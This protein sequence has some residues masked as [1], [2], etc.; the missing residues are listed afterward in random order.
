METV[1]DDR[2]AGSAP[3][4]PPPARASFGLREAGIVF[5]VAL[6]LRLV[7]LWCVRDMPFVEVPIVDARAYDEWGQRIA[8]GDWWGSEVFY[9][10]PLYPYLL[11]SFYAVFGHQ[12]MG[13]HVLQMTMGAA[14]CVLL[15]LGAQALFRD[16][17]VALATGLAIAAYPPAIFFDGLI[18]KQG[19]G[20][21]LLSALLWVWLRQ[22]VLARHGE[23]V[24]AGAL[25]GLLCLTR[26]NALA[27]VPAMAPW[28]VWRFWPAG[29][30][31]VALLLAL[32]A[33]GLAALL[34]PVGLRNLA[35]GDTFALTTSQMGPNFYIGNHAGASGLYEPLLPGRQ[36]PV[37]EATDA[38]LL[39]ER[40]LGRELTRGEVSDHW[41]G[42]GLA[43]VRDEPVAWLGLMLRKTV[44]T[45][46]AFEIPDVEDVYV[47]AD[48][49]PIIRY[50]LPAYHFGWIAALAAAGL[51]FA[52]PRRRDVV[53]LGWL[54]LTYTGSVA[55]F[56]TFARFRY[57]LVPMLAPL[58]G[59]ALVEVARS[60]R[61]RDFGRLLA[62]ATVFVFVFAL[63]GIDLVDR[64]GMKV[65]SLT[66]LG[67]IMLEADRLE[68][69]EVWLQRAEAARPE[70]PDLQLHLAVLREA[71]GRPEEALPHLAE[72]R[73]LAPDDHRSWVLLARI[74][75]AQGKHAEAARARQ[76]AR[77]LD[78]APPASRPVSPP[79]HRDAVQSGR[80]PRGVA[81]AGG[82]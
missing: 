8:A 34:V 12:L 33:L 29:P 3:A 72:M 31:H 27:L 76:R 28:I 68:E 75:K 46:S 81:P 32:F 16:R 36:T 50:G 56:M 63:A 69:A 80:N 23:V 22:Q 51:V 11:G 67:G 15:A 74:L 9:Q 2:R 82:T 30:R 61:G 35:V 49:S 64:E 37:F 52:W 17:S 24:A 53:L 41:L 40:E 62:P 48:W 45:W 1:R 66:N 77:A 71:Q 73:R 10:A 20:L 7:H 54:A 4:A 25:L 21:L 59:L 42:K 58:V 5:A 78:P 70:N 19:L 26:E 57:P 44:L 65:A 79:A 13:V 55:L 47:Y 39:A 38:E 18:G 60:M 14:S 6:V 43:F